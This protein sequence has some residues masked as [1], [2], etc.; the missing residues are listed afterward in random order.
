MATPACMLS[1]HIGLGDAEA[2]Q[3]TLDESYAKTTWAVG[4]A[5]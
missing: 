5:K 4:G 2:S 3:R 1:D